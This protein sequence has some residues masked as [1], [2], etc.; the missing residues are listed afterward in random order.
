MLNFSLSYCFLKFKNTY[1][2]NTGIFKKKKLSS[3]IFF[4][5]A[6]VGVKS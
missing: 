5:N 2:E 3:F 1:E 4:G 6:K